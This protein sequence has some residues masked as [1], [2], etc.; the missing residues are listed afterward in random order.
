MLDEQPPDRGCSP[1]HDQARQARRTDL[2]PCLS[3]QV[4]HQEACRDPNGLG[5]GQ[6]RRLGRGREARPGAVRDGRRH[7]TGSEGS[8]EAGRLEAADQDAVRERRQR[9]RWPVKVA[10]LRVLEKDELTGRLR[11]ARRE[12]YELRFKHAVGQL[13]NWSQ[14]GKVRHD[15]ARIM[16]VLTERELGTEAATGAPEELP[17][18]AKTTKKVEFDEEQGAR[19]KPA[20]EAEAAEPVMEQATVKQP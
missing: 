7:A 6:P 18:A 12:L 4:D 19:E 1:R 20:V 13:E 9:W 5:Q 10:E 11:T 16:T 3:R 8:H 17:A 15:I 2:D 14:I